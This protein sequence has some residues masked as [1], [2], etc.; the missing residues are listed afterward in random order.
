MFKG[1]TQ[2]AQK[3]LSVLAQEEAKRFHADQLIPEHVLLAILREGEGIGYR[4]LRSLKIDTTEIRIEFEKTASGRKGGFMLGDVPLSRRLKS[5]LETAAEE[6]HL[7]GSEYIGTEHLV[8][9]SAREGGSVFETLLGRYGVY[10]EQIRGAVKYLTASRSEAPPKE[11]PPAA[12]KPAARLAA[13]SGVARTPLLDEFARDLTELARADRID[14]VVGREREIRRVVRILARRTKNNPVLIGEPGVGKTA[15]VEGLALRIVAGEVP[16]VLKEK[17]LLTLDMASVV[18]GTKYRGEFEERLKRIMK[19]IFQA[20]NVIL[21]IDELHTVIGAGSA[22]GT[23]DASNM[24]KP[25]LSRGEVQCIG[26]TTLDEYRKYFEKDAALERRFQSVLVEE[27]S[28][29]ETVEI[30][31]GI[32]ERYERFHGVTYSRDAVEAAAVLAHRYLTERFLPDKAIDLLDEA[33]SKRKIENPSRP[34]ELPRI[35][36]EIQRLTEEKLALVSTQN[37]ERAAEIRDSIRKLK[38]RLEEIRG[39]WGADPSRDRALVTERD[40]REVISETTGIPLDRLEE[41]EAGR[42]LGL[43][44]ALHSRVVGQEEAIRAVSTAV[45]RSRAGIADHRRPTGSFIFLGPTGVGKTLVAKTLAE[46]LFGTEEALIRVDMSDFMEKHNAS[47]L[48]GAPP[49]Y[50]GYD[51]GGMLT[52]KVRRRPYSVILFDEIEKA[53]PDVFN[54]LLQLLEEGELRDNLGHTVSFRNCVIIMTSNAGTRDIA[55]GKRLGF[56]AEDMRFDLDS[57]KEAALSEL[58]RQFNPE[59]LNRVDEVVVFHPLSR[60][61]AGSVLDLMIVELER[62]L[63]EKGMALEIRKPAHEWLVEK[64]YDVT[65]GARPMRRLITRAL[66]DPIAAD[67]I[68]GRYSPGWT[69]LV[70]LKGEELVVRPRKPRKTEDKPVPARR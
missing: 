50:V 60:L 53:H 64:G 55:R 44:E 1:L 33:G 41:S 10:Y 9:A 70:E 34:P 48:V 67:M 15:I 25:A 29:A 22:E 46:R 56:H 65:Y 11:E 57:V 63:A 47:R 38:A 54:L 8:I 28:V 58:K 20:G 35:E 19:E 14:P 4:A 13:G 23:I 42:L 26:A 69:V 7:A 21:F 12:V 40:L 39:T 17:R 27:S 2:R 36:E 31:L 32:K 66:E 16:D 43:E 5:L 49:G 51:Q 62:R 45:R 6:A 18:A 52:E 61:Q 68:A 30:L 3:V 59:F 24:L 37:Y